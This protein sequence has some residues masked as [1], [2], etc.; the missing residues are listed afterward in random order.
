MNVRCCIGDLRM[1]SFVCRLDRLCDQELGYDNCIGKRPAFEECLLNSSGVIHRRI[2]PHR[3]VELAVQAWESIGQDVL[4]HAV[5]DCGYISMPELAIL[6]NCPED[7]LT[8]RLRSAEGTAA[9]ILGEKPA[10]AEPAIHEILRSPCPGERRRVWHVAS[11]DGG[12]MGWMHRRMYTRTLN[13]KLATSMHRCTS[14][15]HWWQ[16]GK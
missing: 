1:H 13:H 9:P 7:E 12:S 3:V 15:S 6:H 10:F 16:V 11:D 4:L 2:L 14:I 8:A 5:V